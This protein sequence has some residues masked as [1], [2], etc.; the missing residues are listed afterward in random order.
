MGL[1][2]DAD[3][4]MFRRYFKEMSK[5]LGIRCKYQYVLKD[6]DYTI[7]S[8]LKASYSEPLLVDLVFE[9]R[10]KQKTLRRHGWFSEDKKDEAAYIG[11]VSF[12][13]PN[14]EKGCLLWIPY[15][16]GSEFKPFRVEAISSII[17]YP[18]SWT[19]KLAPYIED[20]NPD[21]FDN[22]GKSN[23]NFLKSQEGED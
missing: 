2:V 15:G 21:S 16:G 5:L 11:H 4:A 23:T 12:D 19:I 1:L 13:T 14:L 8:E 20:K 18:E 9:D 22:Y 17:E 6:K 10:P 7:Y 3:A